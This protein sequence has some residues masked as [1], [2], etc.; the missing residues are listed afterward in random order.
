MID[1]KVVQVLR[2]RINHKFYTIPELRN[3]IKK[4]FH[5]E[6][7]VEKNDIFIIG[8][9]ENINIFLIENE[10]LHHFTPNSSIGE[11][12]IIRKWKK[13]DEYSIN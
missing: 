5:D 3:V 2:E 12:S 11:S 10:K 7:G 6:Y 1:Q 8:N 13:F 4:F 9:I